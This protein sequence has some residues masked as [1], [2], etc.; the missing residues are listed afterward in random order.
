MKEDIRSSPTS[1]SSASSS[2]I[3]AR[4]VID[5]GGRY[6][7]ADANGQPIGCSQ[8]VRALA[9]SARRGASVAPARRIR[10]RRRQERSL[11]LAIARTR[12]FVPYVGE[13]I[14]PYKLRV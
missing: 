3:K 14:P 6:D 9:L 11:P 5:V 7:V 4:R 2:A 8:G 10:A 12:D 13:Y 1:R